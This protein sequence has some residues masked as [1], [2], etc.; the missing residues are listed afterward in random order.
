MTKAL[1]AEKKLYHYKATVLRVVDGDTL[2]T[3]IELGLFVEITKRIRIYRV[4][5]P[6]SYGKAATLEGQAAKLW[7]KTELQ[8]KN[9]ILQTYLDHDDKY[10]R[11]LANVFYE[12]PDGTQVNFAQRLVAA[13][14]GRIARG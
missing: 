11:L 6:E 8:G 2:D 4:N 3:R 5:A 12:G 1:S 13:G 7:A 9:V 10:G 14:H